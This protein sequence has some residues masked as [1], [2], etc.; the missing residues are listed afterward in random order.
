MDLGICP[1]QRPFADMKSLDLSAMLL[2]PA[3][4][5]VMG[6]FADDCSALAN[7]LKLP[8]TTVWFSTPVS[9]GTNITFPENHPTCTRPG[10]VVEVDIC[11]VSM[12]TTTGPISNVSIETWLPSNWTGRFLSTGNGG[13]GG[14]IQYEDIAYAVSRGFAAVGANN[15]H[16]GTI[17]SPFLNNPGTIEDFAY[18]SLHTGV[19]IGKETT[20]A[21]YGKEHTK[22]YYLGCSTGGRQGFKEAQDFPD[23][24]DGIV[25]GAPALAFNNLTS[26]SGHFFTATGTSDK[27]TFLSADLWTVVYKDLLNQCDGLD[28]HVDG[29]IEDPDLCQYRPESLICGAGQTANCLTGVQAQTVRTVFS[30]LY[31]Q[32]GTLVYPRLQPG[33]QPTQILLAG[34]AF[35]YTTD[36][37]QNVI[38]NGT[39]WDPAT[40]GPKDFA[41][42]AA[43]NPGG[44][45]T[46]KGDLSGVKDRGTKVLH[47]H[48]L[49]DPIISSDNSAR[50]Y[51][52]VS[53]TMGLTSAQLDE[54]Y[55]YF[56]ISGMNHCSGGPGASFI[57]NKESAVAGF[58]PERNVL[59]AI[60]KWVEEG[61]APDSILGT[62]FVNGTQGGQVAFTRKHCKYPT[63]NVYKTGDPNSPDSW[64]CV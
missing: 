2:V 38:Y 48:G 64:T 25:A 40:I 23:D 37:F 58:E 41:A 44:I 39:T 54:F 1:I 31:G 56:R 45:E 46:W 62:A 36:W 60:V 49:Q 35:P 11:R 63:R 17:G 27:P 8:N 18:R 16:N 9:A 61:V 26:W 6:A 20:K 53:R 43:Q 13:T 7:N 32:D 50:Y 34:R 30:D 55:R 47:Y 52:H 59:S 5:Y 29:I 21:L 33:A 4:Q 22:S 3:A 14:C 12:L 57:G 28:G 10:Q 42:A 19:V 24:F 15:G 51:N